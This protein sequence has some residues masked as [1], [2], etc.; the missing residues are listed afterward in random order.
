MWRGVVVGIK[1]AKDNCKFFLQPNY[2]ACF[3]SGS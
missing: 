1:K 3:K 2:H